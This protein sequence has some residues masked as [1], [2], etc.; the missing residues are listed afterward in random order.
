MVG[1]AARCVV[2]DMCDAEEDEPGLLDKDTDL[3]DF[4]D[5]LVRMMEEVSQCHWCVTY[6]HTLLSRRC[7]SQVILVVSGISCCSISAQTAGRG[8]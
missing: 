5:R 1:V 2:S 6:S 3:Y 8:M 7:G 4:R